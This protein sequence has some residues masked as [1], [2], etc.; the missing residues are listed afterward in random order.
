MIDA[1]PLPLRAV[2]VEK[3]F[4]ALVD[5]GGPIVR[6]TFVTSEGVRAVL[7]G[8][9]EPDA[10]KD[11]RED[12]LYQQAR[13]AEG[14]VWGAAAPGVVASPTLP[15][16]ISVRGDGGQILGVVRLDLDP[17]KAVAAT[18]DD[19]AVDPGLATLLVERS[20]KVVSQRRA[21]G[22]A[23]EPDLLSIPQVR[24][25][26]ERGESGVL[27]T[28]RD[29]RSV[30]VSYHPLS[31]VDW[32]LVTIADAAPDA[33][34]AKPGT[35]P[36]DVSVPAARKAPPT[37]PTSAPA[38]APATAPAA[39]ASAPPPEASASAAP[40]ASAPPEASGVRT[41]PPPRADPFAPWK[42]YEKGPPR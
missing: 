13:Q 39:S 8:S 1:L 12:A 27:S 37:R 22:V 21:D 40:S 42:I 29:G 30:L 4:A 9:T 2:P 25:A 14:V 3:A 15:A 41:R 6:V 28:E 16:A 24:A 38:A 26:I 35:R 23:A 34:T 32:Y 20:G 33:T 31:S 18:L 36:G 5:P 7:P 10:P 19:A 11:A 17:A